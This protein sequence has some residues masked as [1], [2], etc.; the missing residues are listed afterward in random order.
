MTET[1]AAFDEVPGGTA[2]GRPYFAGP[3]PTIEDW[4]L[5]DVLIL[6]RDQEGTPL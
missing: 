3:V 2:F 6:E 4:T 5:E 1:T